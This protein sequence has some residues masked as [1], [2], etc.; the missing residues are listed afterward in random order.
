MLLSPRNLDRLELGCDLLREL[1]SLL[2]LLLGRRDEREIQRPRQCLLVGHGPVCTRK[3]QLSKRV[4]P[5]V[6]VPEF[7]TTLAR[8]TAG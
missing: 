3:P 8:L 7:L 5:T 4:G 1:H 6:G 2:S